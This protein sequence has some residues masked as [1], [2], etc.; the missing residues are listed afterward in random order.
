V[1][2]EH[3]S[4]PESP[5]TTTRRRSP[6]TESPPASSVHRPPT[7]TAFD[8]KPF[9]NWPPLAAKTATA[10]MPTSAKTASASQTD[11][12]ATLDNING[13]DVVAIRKATSL[14][15]NMNLC[16]PPPAPRGASVAASTAAATNDSLA[17]QLLLP[18]T[19]VHGK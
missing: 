11:L 18:A 2:A 3:S 8:G 15:S 16:L 6:A 14:Y 19:D 12:R 7:G 13:G 17:L 4:S 5:A 9:A 10:V 1:E